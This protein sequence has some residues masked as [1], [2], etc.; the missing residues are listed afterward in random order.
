MR[1]QRLTANCHRIV[2]ILAAAW[3]L[4]T[5]VMAHPGS[6]IGVGYASSDGK[7]RV[8]PAP[9]R[10][11]RWSRWLL[12]LHREQRHPADHCTGSNLDRCDGPGA[13]RWAVHSSNG[14]TPISPWARGRRP[15]HDV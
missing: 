13:H 2:L 15:R 9:K 7:G 5:S 4:S 14:P 6:D 12:V 1:M 11:H 3:L 8:A 10:D